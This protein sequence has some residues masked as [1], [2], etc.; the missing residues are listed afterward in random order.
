M[1]NP[2]NRLEAYMEENENII[3]KKLNPN[4]GNLYKPVI[5]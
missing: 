1:I 2:G 3:A 5:F 4:L